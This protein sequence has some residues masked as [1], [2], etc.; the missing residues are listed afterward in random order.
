MGGASF[1]KMKQTDAIKMSALGGPVSHPNTNVQ[2][3]RRSDLDAR[4]R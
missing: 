2:S 3:L 4:H 1:K